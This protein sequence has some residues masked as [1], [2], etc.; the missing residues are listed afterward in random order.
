MDRQVIVRRLIEQKT[1]G[2]LEI[3]RKKIAGRK[4]KR[5]KGFLVVGCEVGVGG[6]WGSF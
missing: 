5:G 3:F 2:R 1:G 4:V 6:R